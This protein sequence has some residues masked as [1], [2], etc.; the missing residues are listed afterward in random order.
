M[1]KAIIIASFGTTHLDAWNSAIKP[2]EDMIRDEFPEYDATSAF[3]SA[4]VRSM[5]EKRGV[6]T[7][8]PEEALEAHVRKGAASAYI[9]PTHLLPGIEYEK[10][11]GALTQFPQ[12][13]ARLARPLLCG[14]EDFDAILNAMR[15]AFPH[16][17]EAGLVLMGHGS[18][19]SCNAL[20]AQMNEHIHEQ[21]MSNIFVATVEAKPGL[22]EAIEYMRAKGVKRITIAPLLLVAGDHAKNDMAGENGSWLRAFQDAGFD[23]EAVVKGLG[24]YPE[25]RALYA[26]RLRE[27]L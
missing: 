1:K 22:N 16:T 18:E 25:I 8:S 7:S 27:I 13:R 12:L 23:A 2:I 24:E 6:E 9:L 17:G 10:L 20:Y 26:K 21:G 11:Q 14:K 5:L 19:H 15:P 4:R 3:T